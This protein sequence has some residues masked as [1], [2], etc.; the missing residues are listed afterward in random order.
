MKW[1]P[2][3]WGG[4]V[5]CR[6]LV[7]I[8]IGV[9]NFHLEFPEVFEKGG[10][11]CLLGNPPWEKINFEDKEFFI[12]RSPEIALARNKAERKKLMAE[13]PKT[14][15]ALYLE[16]LSTKRWNDSLSVFFRESG[17]YPFTG[18]SRVNL[19]SI[20]A[21]KYESL[22]HINGATG[23][24][25]PTGIILDNNNKDLYFHLIRNN[26]IDIVIDYEN[27]KGIF[28]DV[29][30]M[31][32]FCLFVTVGQKG[33]NQYKFYQ[34]EPRQEG[35][36]IVITLEDIEAINP[37]TKTCPSFRNKRDYE[38][39]K[40]VYK[41]CGVLQNVSHPEKNT[42]NV[43]IRTPFN[44]SNDSVFLKSFGEG[45]LPLY[46]AKYVYQ[47]NHRYC[48]WIGD[49][50]ISMSPGNLANPLFTIRTQYYL[51]KDELQT[52]F[53]KLNWFLV[54]RMITNA[55]NERTMVATIIPEYPCGHSLSLIDTGNIHKAFF[56]REILIP[57]L[58]IFFQ[59]K[60]LVEQTL[61]N[62][63]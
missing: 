42:W 61:V 9:K 5:L 50:Q 22:I 10:F 7:S 43:R 14:N 20:F 11:D 44:M 4:I 37:N 29:H 3:P 30:R 1:P 38:L 59:D 62:G 2:S 46:E 45:L 52:R 54:Y 19:Y 58:L 41:R 56:Y 48:T 63:F 12:S 21:E 15:L 60:R 26:K 49:N 51:S 36:F 27:R 47:Y 18:V 8:Y 40:K 33:K 17:T 55:T 35:E 39:A 31:Y 25:L 28:P 16:Y 32:R 53:G 13:L 24:V 23:N 34:T 6:L 57:F